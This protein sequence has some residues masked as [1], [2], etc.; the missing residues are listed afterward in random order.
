M[1]GLR[2]TEEG[3]MAMKWIGGPLLALV[4]AASS[5]SA[6]SG[7]V[8]SIIDALRTE[9]YGQIDVSKTLLGRTRIE[10]T[11]SGKH[12]E[13][14]VNPATGEILRDY[15]ELIAD[16]SSSES[17]SD[18][19]DDDDSDNDD[20]DDDDD[21]DNSGSGSGNSGSGSGNSGSGSGGSGGGGSDDDD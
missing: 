17:G 6:Q 11:G 19:D 9:G 18:D 15:W 16:G 10:A 14:V 2:R 4:L 21:D 20:D 1:P 12:R 13:I 5:A 3:L 8:G 7:V